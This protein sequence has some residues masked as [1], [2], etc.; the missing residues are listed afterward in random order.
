LG[1][2]FKGLG[3]RV[4]DLLFRVGII[5][6][7]FGDESDGQGFKIYGLRSSIK[8]QDSGLRVLTGGSRIKGR[9][10]SVKV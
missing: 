1:P 9:G 5:G 6:I 8:G 3:F 4:Y 7:G 10:L 2:L